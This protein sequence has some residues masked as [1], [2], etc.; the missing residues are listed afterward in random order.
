MLCFGYFCCFVQ[1]L[2]KCDAISE[3]QVSE[4]RDGSLEA[5]AN[6]LGRDEP[7]DQLGDIQVKVTNLAIAFHL[8]KIVIDY[9]NDL[10][11]KILLYYLTILFN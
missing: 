7:V 6:F 8:K 9:S 11:F 10:Y 4:A 2:E 5:V 1:N 3:Y